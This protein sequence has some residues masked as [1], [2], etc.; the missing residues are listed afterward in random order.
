MPK[1]HLPLTDVTVVLG[2]AN[3]TNMGISDQMHLNESADRVTEA[4]ML[5]HQGITKSILLSGGSG[6]LIYNDEKESTQLIDFFLASGVASA[7]LL[8]DTLSRNTHENVVHTKNML[9][10]RGIDNRPII[11]VT[12]A[13]HMYRAVKCFQKQGFEVIPYPVDYQAGKLLWSPAIVVPNVEGLIIWYK[14]LH[15]WVGIIAY[16]LLGYT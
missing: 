15:E 10:A 7:A 14:L 6:E 8:A 9:K 2:G 4:L 12:S 1:D 13:T 5:Y 3:K 16:K 11:L